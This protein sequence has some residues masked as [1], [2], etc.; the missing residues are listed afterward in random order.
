[1]QKAAGACF[2]VSWLHLPLQRL[3]HSGRIEKGPDVAD[4]LLTC[5]HCRPVVACHEDGRAACRHA[6]GPLTRMQARCR[7][8]VEGLRHELAGH[9]QVGCSAHGQRPERE[10][11][12]AWSCCCSYTPARDRLSPGGSARLQSSCPGRL[13][14]GD[15]QEKKRKGDEEKGF[16][17]GDQISCCDTNGMYPRLTIGKLIA[18]AWSTSV[19][20]NHGSVVQPKIIVANCASRVAQIDKLGQAVSRCGRLVVQTQ[21]VARAHGQVAG[22]MVAKEVVRAV[23]ARLQQRKGR[24][25][26]AALPR[27]LLPRLLLPGVRQGQEQICRVK[28]V[29]DVVDLRDIANIDGLQ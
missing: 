8:G 22:R 11:S 18:G 5:L 24:Q 9:E 3:A 15:G 10:C 16:Y 25:I 20:V 4:V 21:E 7:A 1:M 19:G 17:K 14:F 13:L 2:E 29:D 26:D 6:T 23:R 28:I 27:L 12:R